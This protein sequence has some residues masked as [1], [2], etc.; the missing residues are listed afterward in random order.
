MSWLHVYPK[1]SLGIFLRLGIQESLV[2][3]KKRQ[4]V[5]MPRETGEV[6]SYEANVFSANLS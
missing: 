5:T 1:S 4:G 6:Q 3:R 2:S